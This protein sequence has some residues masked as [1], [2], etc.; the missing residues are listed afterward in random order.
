MK[1]MV[2]TENNIFLFI[3]SYIYDVSRAMTRVSVLFINSGCM[4]YDWIADPDSWKVGHLI[5]VK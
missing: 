1:S 2:E 4:P 5:K 3:Y